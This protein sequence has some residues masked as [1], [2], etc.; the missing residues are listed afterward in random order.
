MPEDMI[1]V[2]LLLLSASGCIYFLGRRQDGRT[3]LPP[4]E[5]AYAPWSAID[6][7]I[8]CA[9]FLAVGILASVTAVELA[10]VLARRSEQTVMILTIAF[11]YTFNL[12]TLAL[13][14]HYAR[15]SN[16]P[17]AAM[18][19]AVAQPFESVA[20]GFVFFLLFIPFEFI[21]PSSIEAIWKAIFHT[22][23][24]LQTTIQFFQTAHAPGAIAVT[25]AAGVIAPIVEET[26]FRGFIQRGFENTFGI[27]FGVVLTAVLFSVVHGLSATAVEIFPLA[28]LL[29]VLYARTRNI[30]IN[31]AFHASFNTASLLLLLAQRWLDQGSGVDLGQLFQ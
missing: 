30:L 18:G 12:L 27:V 11:T 20:F 5:T 21:Y 10:G 19:F 16:W 4:G 31:I 14:Y 6:S 1:A 25:V 23:P 26:V 17:T 24:E 2:L 9:V 7:G 22:E 13:I 15:R 29:S 28:L 3:I 8:V